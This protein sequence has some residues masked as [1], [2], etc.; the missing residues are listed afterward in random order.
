MFRLDRSVAHPS[1][2]EFK[3]RANNYMSTVPSR[4]IPTVWLFGGAVI[5]LAA[6]IIAQYSDVPPLNAYKSAVDVVVEL[7]KSVGA[8]VFVI[9]GINAVIETGHWRRYFEERLKDI[10]LQ[11]N[12]LDGLDAKAL[13]NLHVRL[14]QAQFKES[15][16]NG[17]DSIFAYYSS[18]IHQHIGGPYRED[19][20]GDIIITETLGDLPGKV[21]ETIRFTCRKN[22]GRIQESVSW[23]PDGGQILDSV[24]I[25]V[26]LPATG[27]ET[28]I[29][30]SNT[31]DDSDGLPLVELQKLKSGISLKG[32]LI[33]GSRQDLSI[34]DR[35][36]IAIKV[37]YRLRKASAVTWSFALPTKRFHLTVAADS[38]YEMVYELFAA[39]EDAA[40]SVDSPG[41]LSL[42]YSDWMLPQ[43]GVVIRLLPK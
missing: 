39:N 30:E 19:A 21:D 36:V 32:V 24:S 28:T 25:T 11:Q 40:N 14:L 18:N 43:N 31:S 20:T 33:D 8:A 42:H 35:L 41:S 27:L 3:S 9:G 29:F 15:S 23:R 34:C 5:M 2:A 7:L 12:Y 37:K 22:G 16:I 10:V 1:C 4:S 38:R 26:R 17:D 13:S 6:I